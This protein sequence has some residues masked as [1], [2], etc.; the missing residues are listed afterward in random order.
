[1]MGRVCRQL[2]NDTLRGLVSQL[3]KDSVDQPVGQVDLLGH[4]AGLPGQAVDL[5][6]GLA[7]LLAELVD[8]LAELAAVGWAGPPEAGTADLL[9][10]EVDLL[11]AEPGLLVVK[12]DLLAE[13]AAD[14][15]FVGG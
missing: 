5:L 15:V 2:D 12:A 10:A 7:D 4:Q 11:V 13:L 3:F 9:V 14:Q 8:H 6:A 1:M